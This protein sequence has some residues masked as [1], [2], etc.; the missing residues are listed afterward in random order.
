MLIYQDMLLFHP[1]PS[2]YVLEYPED[3]AHH[4][5]ISRKHKSYP[6]QN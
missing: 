4:K 2:L 3:Y 6:S 5:P 1:T